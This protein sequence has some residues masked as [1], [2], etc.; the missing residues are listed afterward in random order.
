MNQY[1]GPNEVRIQTGNMQQQ[2]YSGPPQ[3]VQFVQPHYGQGQY[4]G[5]QPQYAGGQPVY[6]VQQPQQGRGQRDTVCC[7]PRKWFERILCCC[8]ICK[9]F[10]VFVYIK[11][12]LCKFEF[13]FQDQCIDCLGDCGCCLCG[14]CNECGDCDC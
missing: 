1:V 10:F 12:N 6:V 7:I 4:M 3:N 11:F 2:Y 8:F 14:I 9:F 5:G 13:L